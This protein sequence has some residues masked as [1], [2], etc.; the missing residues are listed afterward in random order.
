MSGSVAGAPSP[1]DGDLRRREAGEDP[2]VEGEAVGGTA[3]D[4]EA[5]DLA[6]GVLEQIEG[7]VGIVGE[8]L[9]AGSSVGERPGERP[10]AGAASRLAAPGVE[11]PQR[12]V[13]VVE[14]GEGG[15]EVVGHGGGGYRL[16][17]ERSR[18]AP[19]NP[20]C[21]PVAQVVRAGDS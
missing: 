19:Y 6:A 5:A 12:G 18:L 16:P 13:A 3:P 21:G 14:C 10:H 17:P 9:Q 2:L 1:I 4:L 8:P 20:G 15:G 11:V 7:G